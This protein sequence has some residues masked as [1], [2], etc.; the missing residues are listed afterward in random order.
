MLLSISILGDCCNVNLVSL[1][2]QNSVCVHG[3]YRKNLESIRR[4]GLKRMTRVHVH[5]ATGLPHNGVIS[6]KYSKVYGSVKLF[7]VVCLFH[8][9]YFSNFCAR[10]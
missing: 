6:G 4:A 7:V 2:F 10:S 5:F 9:M 3:T 8:M 1:L